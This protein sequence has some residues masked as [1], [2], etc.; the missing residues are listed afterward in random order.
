VPVEDSRGSNNGSLL[1]TDTIS[2][3]ASTASSRW[4]TVYNAPLFP[5]FHVTTPVSL[6]NRL[7]NGKLDETHISQLSSFTLIL[8]YP[9]VHPGF[10]GLAARDILP[11]QYCTPAELNSWRSVKPPGE[12]MIVIL[13]AF[14]HSVS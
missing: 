2:G 3:M 6:K 13:T 5:H 4:V 8:T 11:T 7:F 10:N 12:W 1:K 9:P 14:Y